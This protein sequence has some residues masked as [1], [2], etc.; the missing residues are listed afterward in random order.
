MGFRVIPV[1]RDN[2]VGGQMFGQGELWSSRCGDG[3]ACRTVALEQLGWK[4]LLPLACMPCSR[5]QRKMLWSS[6]CTSAAQM[7]RQG[8]CAGDV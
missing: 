1:H 7:S 2:T 3:Q 4:D 5:A 6:K 8:D